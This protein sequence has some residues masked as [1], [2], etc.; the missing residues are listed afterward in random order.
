MNR[1]A[2][3]LLLA[4]TLFSPCS[5]RAESAD[6]EDVRRLNGTVE[7]L[8]EGQE[9]LRKQIQS[10]KDQLEK[11]R[12][13]NAQ[14]RQELAGNRDMVTRE[15]LNQ[16]VEQL[17]EVDRKR[18]ADAEYVKTQL[19][20]IARDVNKSLATAVRDPVKDSPKSR[21][22]TRTQDPK[23][24]SDAATPPAPEVKLPDYMYEH[25]VKPGETLGAIITAYNQEK[26]LKITTAHVMAAN[27]GL[28]DPK[29]IRVGQKLNIPE[30]K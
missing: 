14:L 18:A 6:A 29:R 13:E 23:S 30:V 26:G 17:R 27:P 24:V 4:A 8:G 10:L 16:V 28:K 9:S 22:A 12:A 1:F 21:G 25:V 7:A 3:F 20:D 19:A 5:G 2:A 15:Q 11:V